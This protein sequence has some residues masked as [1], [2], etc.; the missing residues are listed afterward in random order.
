MFQSQSC[1]PMWSVEAKSTMSRVKKGI[2]KIQDII[3]QRKTRKVY[4]Q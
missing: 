4:S 2:F 1:V 3:N